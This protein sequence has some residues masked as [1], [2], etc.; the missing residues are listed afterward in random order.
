MTVS[1]GCCSHPN[2]DLQWKRASRAKKEIQKVQLEEKGAPGNGMSEPSPVLKEIKS[3]KTSLVLTGIKEVVTSRQ[4][5]TQ[6]SFL[7]VKRN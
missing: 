7:R 3:L 2:A 6:L 5:P 4:D 1:R